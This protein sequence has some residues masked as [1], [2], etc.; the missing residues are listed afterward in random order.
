MTARQSPWKKGASGRSLNGICILS[1][2]VSSQLLYGVLRPVFRVHVGPGCRQS[3]RYAHLHPG[4]STAAQRSRAARR[5]GVCLGGASAVPYS[6]LLQRGANN[7]TDY[8]ATVGCVRSIRILPINLDALPQALT[9]DRPWARPLRLP[10]TLRW[11]PARFRVNLVGL[12]TRIVGLCL[13]WV[14]PILFCRCF[15]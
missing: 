2:P 3:K 15:H 6:V 4:T 10:G 11:V 9:Q 8:G 1:E 7:I 12:M 13:P 14:P 5:G